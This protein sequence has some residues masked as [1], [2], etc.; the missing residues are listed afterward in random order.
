MFIFFSG[1]VFVLPKVLFSQ[2]EYEIIEPG[3]LR[4]V[5]VWRNRKLMVRIL[6]AFS[7]FGLASA[8]KEKQ[9]FHV[10]EEG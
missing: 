2:C 8:V 6:S 10:V 3:T 1:V 4:A 9:L 5:I 7:E